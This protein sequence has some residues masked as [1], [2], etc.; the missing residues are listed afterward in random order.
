ERSG[1]GRVRDLGAGGAFQTATARAHRG[2][3]RRRGLGR[4]GWRRRTRAARRS[5]GQER[6]TMAGQL[7]G[8][9]AIVTGSGSGLGRG[10]ADELAAEGAGVAVAEIDPDSGERAAAELAA[11]GV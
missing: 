6:R 5:L 7:E 11:T 8:R 2:N 4:G 1:N 3:R 10:I 9:V